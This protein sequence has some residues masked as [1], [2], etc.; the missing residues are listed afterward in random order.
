MKVL[1][2]ELSVERNELDVQLNERKA[3]LL[4]LKKDIRKEEENLQ[5]ILG[6]VTKHKMGMSLGFTGFCADWEG[7]HRALE[8]SSPWSSNCSLFHLP[9]T[10]TRAGNTGA[11]EEWTGRFETTTWAEGQWAGKDPDGCSRGKKCF[12]GWCRNWEICASLKP[13]VT[14]SWCS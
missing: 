5:G 2:A 8:F 14:E 3:Q 4:V 7:T 13:W 12:C 10:E 1:L 9:R 6:Q 11:W